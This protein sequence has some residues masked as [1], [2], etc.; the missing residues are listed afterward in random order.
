M[1]GDQ[2]A[3]LDLLERFA[4]LLERDDIKVELTKRPIDVESAKS[5]KSGNTAATSA[6]PQFTLRLGRPIAP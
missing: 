3:M 6:A 2:R 4:Q 5:F 1:N